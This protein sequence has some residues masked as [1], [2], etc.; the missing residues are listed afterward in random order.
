VDEGPTVV[1]EPFGAVVDQIMLPGSSVD[2]FAVPDFEN[3]Y[4]TTEKG[5]S[6]TALATN[7]GLKHR[8]PAG[9]LNGLST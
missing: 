7:R 6:G 4:R 9:A 2:L 1:F 5:A 8:A 3:Q